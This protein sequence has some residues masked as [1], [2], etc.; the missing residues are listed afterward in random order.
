MLRSVVLEEN[1]MWL[2]QL[3]SAFADISAGSL[4]FQIPSV[5]TVFLEQSRQHHQWNQQSSSFPQVQA[6]LQWEDNPK[7]T[8]DAQEIKLE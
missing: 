4:S 6:P 8:L 3:L 5:R 2:L 7:Q 1:E